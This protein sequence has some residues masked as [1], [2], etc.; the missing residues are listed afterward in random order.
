V[1]WRGRQ[2]V[3]VFCP[4]EEVYVG[5]V[6]LSAVDEPEAMRDNNLSSMGALGYLRFNPNGSYL[7][8]MIRSH[9]SF[10]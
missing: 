5:P 9:L 4:G 8:L 3:P 2:T 10:G 1:G 6:R 7:S